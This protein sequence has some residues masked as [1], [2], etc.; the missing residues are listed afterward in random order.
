MCLARL[1]VQRSGGHPLFF[2]H[3]DRFICQHMVGISVQTPFTMNYTENVAHVHAVD[4]R[5]SP[6]PPP[7]LRRPGDK[8]SL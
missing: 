7:L 2:R 8:T 3:M 6:P 5:P 1:L 4:T